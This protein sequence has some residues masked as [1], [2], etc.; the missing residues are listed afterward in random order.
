MNPDIGMLHTGPGSFVHD[1][2]EVFKPHMVD[3]P[4]FRRAREGLVPEEYDAGTNRCHL[5]DELAQRVSTDLRQSIKQD[6]IDEFVGIFR[7]AVM[8]DGQFCVPS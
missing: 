8:N 4:V 7:D 2:A 3:A 1:V 5:S 6:K